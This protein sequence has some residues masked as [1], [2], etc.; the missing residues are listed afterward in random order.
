MWVTLGLIALAAPGAAAAENDPSTVVQAVEA[1]YAGVT[2]LQADFVQTT[3]SDVFGEERQTGELVLKRPRKMR[4]T[5]AG[6]S[7]AA[8]SREFVTDGRTMWVYTRDENQVIQYDDVSTQ[9]ASADSLLQSLDQLDALF[10]VQVM[11]PSAPGHVSLDLA[12]REASGQVKKLHLDLDADLLLERVV[13]TDP[14]DNVT[15]LAFTD[16][17]LNADVPDSTFQFQVPSGAE[18]ISAGGM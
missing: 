9:S 7:A 13:I 1:R 18:V 14:F 15:E 12:P 10:V 4:W 8:V 6:A 16:V 5:F 17:R 11:E 2:V 3:R